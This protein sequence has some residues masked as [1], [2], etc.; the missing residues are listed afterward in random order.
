MSLFHGM[1]QSL[2]T[3]FSSN[4]PSPNSRAAKPSQHRTLLI[5]TKSFNLCKT[6]SDADVCFHAHNIPHYEPFIDSFSFPHPLVTSVRTN[7]EQIVANGS[8]QA[9]SQQSTLEVSEAQISHSSVMSESQSVD[10][11]NDINCLKDYIKSTGS[12]QTHIERDCQRLSE[13]QQQLENDMCK[14]RIFSTVIRRLNNQ[15]SLKEIIIDICTTTLN[16]ENDGCF[17]IQSDCLA[18]LA[19]VLNFEYH[20]AVPLTVE[21]LSQQYKVSFEPKLVNLADVQQRRLRRKYNKAVAACLNDA[22]KRVNQNYT[23]A[24][25]VVACYGT[26]VELV[27]NEIQNQFS[28]QIRATYTNR[29]YNRVIIIFGV[30]LPKVL[31]WVGS[32]LSEAGK[33][34]LTGVM[35]GI[36]LL[37]FPLGGTLNFIGAIRAAHQGRKAHLAQAKIKN[38]QKS[39]GERSANICGERLEKLQSISTSIR[40]DRKQFRNRSFIHTFMLAVAVPWNIV[41]F[42]GSVSGIVIYTAGSAAAVSILA[43][44]GPVGWGLLG[45]WF[46]GLACF[47]TYR[48]VNFGVNY[49][50]KKHLKLALNGDAAATEWYKNKYTIGEMSDEDLKKKIELSLIERDPVFAIN[51][52]YDL[53][54]DELNDSGDSG[55]QQGAVASFLTEHFDNPQTVR[56]LADFSPKQAKEIIARK[57]KI[58]L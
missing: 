27:A 11:A 58:R 28:G 13:Y 55:W 8:N 9:E 34:V 15:D 23:K 12:K 49:Y 32:P 41:G 17:Q 56:L 44:A 29:L 52:L 2:P 50:Q 36:G 20:Q 26:D 21:A 18:L 10:I 4:I 16:L 47:A 35:S 48:L 37:A 22:K 46:I 3:N 19:R 57:F 33:V 25:K 53:L 31:S 42:I 24:C 1:S 7:P 6:K 14:F 54:I 39:I 43:I 45:V 5:N 51:K 38:F 40:A 30:S